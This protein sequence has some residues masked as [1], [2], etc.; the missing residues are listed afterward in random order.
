MGF[1][2]F[3]IPWKPW[4]PA[5]ALNLISRASWHT[6]QGEQM[7]WT[8]QSE[9]GSSGKAYLARSFC[10]VFAAKQ[11]VKKGQHEYRRVLQ[12]QLLLSMLDVFC[13]YRQGRQQRP[14]NKVPQS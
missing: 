10:L 8:Q 2:G 7:Q 4:P 5:T 11:Q 13:P 12:K 14:Q 1:L 9:Q 6:A 3:Y